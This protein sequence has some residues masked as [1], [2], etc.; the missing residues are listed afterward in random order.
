MKRVPG[1]RHRK[2]RVHGG[3]VISRGVVRACGAKGRG[4]RYRSPKASASVTAMTNFVFTTRVQHAPW[5]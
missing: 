2:V 5:Q 3:S 1:V 4:N